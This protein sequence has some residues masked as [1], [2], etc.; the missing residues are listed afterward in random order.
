MLAR[1]TPMYLL[2]PRAGKQQKILHPG[3][4]VESDAKTFV[5]EFEESIEPAVGAD[6]VAYGEVG[7][8][9]FQQGAVVSELRGF[10]SGAGAGTSASAGPIIAFGR[11]GEVVSAEQRQTFRV[12][13][14]MLDLA[15]QINRE[16]ACQIVDMSP[17][18]LAAIAGGLFELGSIVQISFTHEGHAVSASARVQTATQRPDGKFR[19]GLLVSTRH[20]AA[21]KAL[22]S[23]SSRAQRLQLRRLAGAA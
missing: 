2:I 7:G 22:E 18:G 21:R 10:G 9:F 12:S 14:A 19:Y 20:V 16:D 11:V 23:I 1:S 5:A 15:A 13:V 8:K 4:V 3:R 6:V 17:E